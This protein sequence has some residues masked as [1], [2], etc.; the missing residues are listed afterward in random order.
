MSNKESLKRDTKENFSKSLLFLINHRGYLAEQLLIKELST[1]RLSDLLEGA[2]AT[3]RETETISKILGVP[4]STFQVT[5]D[6]KIIPLEIAFAEI[7]YASARMSKDQISKLAK[8]M[9][10]L[11]C[12]DEENVGKILHFKKL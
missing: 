1:T 11:V 8:Q 4:L 2:E 3:F 12:K 9:I 7:M 6:K 10:S 5:E